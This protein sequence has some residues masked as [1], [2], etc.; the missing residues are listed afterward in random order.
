MRTTIR[1]GT[2]ALLISKLATSVAFEPA[3]LTTTV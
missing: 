2:G 1:A 3:A